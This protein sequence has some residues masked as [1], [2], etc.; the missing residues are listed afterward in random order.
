M[1]PWF[2]P[3]KTLIK[4]V[5]RI[6]SKKVKGGDRDSVKEK[7]S[8]AKSSKDKPKTAPSLTN[9]GSARESTIDKKDI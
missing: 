1:T 2:K 6:T 3:K 4:S 7:P 9:S 5:D 8:K